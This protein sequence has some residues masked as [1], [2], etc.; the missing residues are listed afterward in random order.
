LVGLDSGVEQLVDYPY[1]CTEQLSSRLLPLLPL[2]E[3]ARDFK[4][5]LPKNTNAIVEKTVADVLSRQRGDGGFGMWPDSPESS[6]WVSAYALWVLDIAKKNGANVP[7]RTIERGRA[8]VRRYLAELREDELYLATAAFVVDVLAEVG[9]PDTGYMSRLYDSRKKLPLFARAFL[10]HALVVSK[11]KHDM[12]ATLEREIEGQLRIDANMAFA[13]ENLGDDYA[14]LMDSP[15]RTSALVLRALVAANPRHPMASKLA[16]GLLA[17]R[18][19]GNWR[20]TQEAAFALLSLDAYRRAQE[21][22]TPDYVAKVWLAGGELFSHEMRGK[23]LSV[24]EQSIPAAKLGRGSKLVFEKRGEGTLFYEARL[25]YAR[26]RLPSQPLDRGFYVQKTLRAVTPEGLPDAIRS[27]PDIGTRKFEGGALAIADIVIVTPSPRE[28][29]VID[30]PLPAGFEAVDAN[31]STTASW[32]RVAHSGGEP[33]STD[34]DDCDPEDW[35]DDLAHGRAFLDSWYR[36]ELRD[37]RV[38][39][40]V[41]HMAAGMYHYRYLARATTLGTF[42]VPPTKAEEMYTP[43]TFGRTAAEV[44]E[45]K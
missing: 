35:E 17:V 45:V 18:R 22:A 3:L 13:N 11:Q 2:R 44:V 5:A 28:F 32:L 16:R 6:P 42:V 40:F 19:G 10:L 36:R 23:S 38:V 37:D 41:D 27:I 7:K 24:A 14:V 43:E 39:F 9:A 1:G 15:A 30:D 21:K 33:G 31:L 12:V 8:Y 20:S 34:C 4:F 29:V 25:T 26:R